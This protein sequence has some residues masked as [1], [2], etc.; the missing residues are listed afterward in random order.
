MNTQSKAVRA[1]IIDVLTPLTGIGLAGYTTIMGT[2]EPWMLPL[3]GG[4]LGLPWIGREPDTRSEP[5]PTGDG[6]Q[7]SARDG[8][9]S[10]APTRRSSSG[11]SQKR[12]KR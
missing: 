12:G 7:G 2:L 3:I 4:L 11:R 6:S 9:S 8:G 5:A 10:P 1:W